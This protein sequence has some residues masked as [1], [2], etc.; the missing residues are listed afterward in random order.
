MKERIWIE[1]IV[2]DP[3]PLL[4]VDQNELN[5]LHLEFDEFQIRDLEKQKEITSD[6]I[7]L[8]AWDCNCG[9]FSPLDPELTG[10]HEYQAAAIWMNE[11]YSFNSGA[12]IKKITL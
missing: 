6:Y 2:G 9:I 11:H 12:K 7:V 1:G 3:F 10:K 4:I 8:D 5:E